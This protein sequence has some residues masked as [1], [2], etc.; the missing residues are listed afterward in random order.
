[1][2]KSIL[3]IG[4]ATALLSLSAQAAGD[5]EI[6]MEAKSAIMKLGKTLKAEVVKNMKAHGPQSTAYFC[7]KSA[8]DLTK[9]VNATYPKGISVKRISLKNRNKNAYP[10][11]KDEFA[12]LKKLQKQVN[13]GKKLPKMIVEKISENHY[14]VYKPI[15]VGKKC[16][17]CHGD[18]KHR[19]KDAYKTIKE[20]YPNDK[21]IGY[22]LNDFR[23]AFVAEIIK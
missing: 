11:A 13:N 2:K 19:N 4:I 16:L 18:A 12:M 17:V 9:R 23:G 22:K 3:T 1:M 6:K 20:K 21:A 15:F 7:Y 5:K 8:G 10:V 14:K